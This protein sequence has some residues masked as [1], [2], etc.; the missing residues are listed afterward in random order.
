M[1]AIQEISARVGRVT[2]HGIAANIRVYYP[3]WLLRA[4]VCLLVLANLINLGADLGAMGDAV[5]LMMGGSARLYVIFLAAACCHHAYDDAA[6]SDGRVHIAASALA[7]RLAFHGRND[8]RPR[9]HV[10][11]V[12]MTAGPFMHLAWTLPCALIAISVKA[13]V[14]AKAGSN[15]AIF[16]ILQ[17]RQ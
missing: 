16:G 9:N 1:A 10:L 8:N 2:G 7:P 11:D 17:G 3:A 4:I 15:H 6:Q 13:I 14:H 12:V 5:H